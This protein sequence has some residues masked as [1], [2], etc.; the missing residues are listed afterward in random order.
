M[1]V[2]GVID[3]KYNGE[4]AYL[5]VFG[6]EEFE[7][8]EA[9]ATTKVESGSF[10]FNGLDDLAILKDKKMPQ[11]AYI[12]LFDVNMREEEL[13]EENADSPMATI[14]LEKG[15]VKVVF[16]D[17]SVSVGGTPKNEEFNKMHLAIKNFVEFTSSITAIEDLDA[18][19][20]DA[21]GRDGRAQL[22]ML[23]QALKDQSYLFIKD[24]MTN[25]VG[26]YLLL[27]SGDDM[28]TTR[29]ILDLIATSSKEFQDK[30]EIKELNRILSEMQIEM[31]DEIE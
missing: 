12:S 5:Y 9:I 3:N 24:N 17:S 2:T 11:I 8:L 22:Q 31:V 13:T 19:A 25:N 20:L 15:A 30:P 27:Q 28:F 14:I 4:T 21:E 29:Q 10:V 1:S 23:D 18:M 16:E 6:D 7:K 26:E